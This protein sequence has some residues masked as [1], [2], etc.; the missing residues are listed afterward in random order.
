M[1]KFIVFGATLL[2]LTIRLSE[3]IMKGRP[4]INMSIG[5][6][7]YNVAQGI[8]LFKMPV[9]LSTMY[10]TDRIGDFLASEI[11]KHD[12]EVLATN[13]VPGFSGIYVGVNDPGGETIIDRV[14]TALFE[15]HRIPK[16][17]WKEY[18][19]VVV[20]SSVP[21]RILNYLRDVKNKYPKKK[22]CLEISGRSTVEHISPYLDMFD[23]YISNY[24]EAVR[25][26][27]ELQTGK[28]LKEIIRKIYDKGPDV[29][30]VTADKRA[31]YCGYEKK[32]EFK[33][34]KYPVKEVKEIASTIGAGDSVT[35][36][37]CAAYYGYGLSIDESID[38]ALEMAAEK[39]GVH[40]PV[41]ARL[42]GSVKKIVARS[43]NQ[44]LQ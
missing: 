43:K 14:D 5:G 19:V 27:E 36:S 1:K 11:E 17:D 24:K 22:F 42:P 30:I 10:G 33:V 34:K 2:D 18:D 12:I 32:T 29:V 39:I 41:I 7:G 3:D 44:N 20:I 15:K 23:F 13:R 21:R 26:G 40:E 38:V 4:G 8:S 28:S 35:A 6:K 25:F 31:V 37:F 16:L 9:A